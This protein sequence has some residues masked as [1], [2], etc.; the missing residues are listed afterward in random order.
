[1]VQDTL[2]VCAVPSGTE[3]DEPLQKR[4][5]R[6]SMDKCQKQNL[7]VGEKGEVPDRNA[8]GWKVEGKKKGF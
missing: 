5:I 4:R 7:Q 1:M 6:K 2:G 8:Q 3:A